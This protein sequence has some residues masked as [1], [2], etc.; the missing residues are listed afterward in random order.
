MNFFSTFDQLSSDATRISYLS[1]G[2]LRSCDPSSA[3]EKGSIAVRA[4]VETSALGRQPV[5]AHPA[6]LNEIDHVFVQQ[7]PRTSM[8][9]KPLTQ[10]PN[11]SWRKALKKAGLPAGIRFHDCRHRFATL[12]KRTRTDDRLMM[13]LGGWESSNRWSDTHISQHRTLR[14]LHTTYPKYGRVEV[15]CS[16]PGRGQPL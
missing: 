7:G 14:E 10:V 2:S 1:T 16:K 12:H 5:Q 11:L 8:I 15:N 13:H 3:T 6:A 4:K 9:G